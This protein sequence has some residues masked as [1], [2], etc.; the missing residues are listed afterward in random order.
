MKKVTPFVLFLSIF[1]AFAF[2]SVDKP[3]PPPVKWTV[4]KANSVVKFSVTRL[5][6][7]EVEGVFKDFDGSMEN[8]KPDFSDAKISFSVKTGTLN[9]EDDYRDEHIKGEDFL[10]VAKYPLMT[11]VS[12]SFK[13]AGGSNY[14][15]AGNLTIHGKTLPVT[16]DVVYGGTSTVAGKQKAKFKANAEIN[17]FDYDLKW[18]K[19]T[20]AGGLVVSKEVKIILDIEMNKG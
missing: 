1:S 18:S 16:F 11:F 2:K 6:I 7:E 10:D 9:S 19:L 17:R 14:K 13:P 4:D 15:L 3:T 8:T 20:E 5:L 12:T